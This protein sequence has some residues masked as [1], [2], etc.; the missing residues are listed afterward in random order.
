MEIAY[1]TEDFRTYEPEVFRDH[2]GNDIQMILCEELDPESGRWEPF[3][4]DRRRKNLMDIMF[5]KDDL[6]RARRS[7]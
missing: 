2:W 3:Y 7:A 1:E 5:S 6:W 4:A